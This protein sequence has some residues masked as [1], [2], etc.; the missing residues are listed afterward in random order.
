MAVLR[1][2]FNHLKLSGRQCLPNF[3]REASD[4]LN[5][6][7]DEK[8]LERL[9]EQLYRLATHRRTSSRPLCEQHIDYDWL[10]LVLVRSDAVLEYASIAS[11]IHPVSSLMGA[12]VGQMV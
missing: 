4:I 8:Q 11:E 3:K 6:Y 10:W 12:D 2:F 9:I 7:L 1:D 5:S